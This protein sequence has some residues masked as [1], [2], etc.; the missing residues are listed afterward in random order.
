MNE[1]KPSKPAIPWR[2]W[3]A[4]LHRDLGYLAV[5]LTLVYAVSGIAVNHIS[6][7]NPNYARV[8]ET[9]TIA[10]IRTDQA[11]ETLVAEA[12]AHLKLTEAPR[13]SAQP[14]DDTLLI[15]YPDLQYSVDLPSG[16]VLKEGTTR[17]PVLYA[18]NRLHLNTPK[19]LWTWI[20]DAYAASLAFLALSGLFI[21]KGRNGLLGRGAWL[22]GIG[23][24]V[25]I[26]YWIWWTTRG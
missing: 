20:A 16:R 13:S 5:G 2:R 23:V 26:A 22:T 9:L 6:D 21:L 10:P 3:N 12:L 7:W 17:R 4:V 24:L 19:G 18:L 1:A 14:D 8:R 25:P 11:E 15:F